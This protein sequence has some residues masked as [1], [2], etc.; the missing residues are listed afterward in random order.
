MKKTNIKSKIQQKKNRVLEDSASYSSDENTAPIKGLGNFANIKFDS[1]N[2]QFGDPSKLFN[3]SDMGNPDLFK[4]LD[5][6]YVASGEKGKYAYNIY[7]YLIF[8]DTE[9]QK[10]D[11][12][13]LPRMTG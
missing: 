4:K 3:M 12:A 9:E 8:I 5:N 7:S 1:D 10:F 11:M 6:I 13:K 2:M